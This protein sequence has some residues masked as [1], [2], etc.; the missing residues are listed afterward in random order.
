MKKPKLIFKFRSVDTIKEFSRIKDIIQNNQLYIPTIPQ[1]NDPFEG[2]INATFAIAGNS[3]TRAQDKDFA[4]VLDR[5]RQTRVLSLSEDCF[6]PQLWAY[7]CND[8]HGV[9]LCFKTDKSFNSI[10]PVNYPEPMDVGELVTEPSR[11]QIYKLLRDSLYRKQAGWQYEREWRM[12]FQPEL[13]DEGI[14]IAD[15][16]STLTFNSSELVGIIIGDK[17]DDDVKKQIIEIAQ[18]KVMIFCVHTGAL[19]GKVKVYEYGYKYPGD[20]LEADYIATVDEL[21]KRMGNE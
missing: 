18:D 14:E 3:I 20:G 8:Y 4:P 10:E 9:C 7:Y 13:D 2:R 1:L 15:A 17:L 12:V 19:T 5:K 11:K 6:S 16:K 21:Y